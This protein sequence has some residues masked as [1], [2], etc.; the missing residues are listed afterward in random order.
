M[1]QD[2]VDGL[3]ELRN[4]TEIKIPAVS[5]TDRDE[6]A[7]DRGRLTNISI[8]FTEQTIIH[9]NDEIGP[10]MDT[11]VDGSDLEPA[12][13]VGYY[14]YLSV[15]AGDSNILAYNAGRNTDDVARRK[16]S[17]G[18]DTGQKPNEAV[19]HNDINSHDRDQKSE[20]HED[21]RRKDTNGIDTGQNSGNAVWR[22]DTSSQDTGQNAGQGVKCTDTNGTYTGQNAVE[23]IKCTDTNGTDT[24]QNAVE[25]IKC[26]DTNGKDTGQNAVEGI[27][28]ADT[29][30]TF[31]GQYTDGSVI[32]EYMD[33]TDKDTSEQCED[34]DSR[35]SDT[36]EPADDMSNCL[37]SWIDD[38]TIARK[39]CSDV[40]FQLWH[41]LMAVVTNRFATPRI[42][43]FYTG[44][45]DLIETFTIGST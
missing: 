5:L 31:T 17:N 7:T 39:S 37:I 34:E 4:V 30:G 42:C 44:T 41:Q 10:G 19:R 38:D 25:G 26:T 23:G 14:H 18:Q 32:D 16:G 28:C 22:K 3:D 35:E 33:D 11:V 40:I 6:N 21:V 2:E 45:N 36:S 13:K 20:D 9:A 24:G 12:E 8:R 1:R 27:K 43:Q 15:N 29:N